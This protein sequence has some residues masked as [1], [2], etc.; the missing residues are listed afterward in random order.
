MHGSLSVRRIGN[1]ANEDA[2]RKTC[3]KRFHTPPP[4]MK[5]EPLEAIEMPQSCNEGNRGTVALLP[6]P[7][8]VTHEHELATNPLLRLQ[9]LEPIE[10][11]RDAGENG[12]SRSF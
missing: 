2:D 5:I 9:L 4:K 1:C 10:S 11:F 12:T 6:A 7:S 8:S 3:S